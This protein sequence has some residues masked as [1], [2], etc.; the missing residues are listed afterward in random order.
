[1]KKRHCQIPCHGI[2]H[3]FLILFVLITFA[4]TEAQEVVGKAE[5]PGERD[6]LYKKGSEAYKEKDYLTA[7]KNL[8][9]FLV[10]NDEKLKTEYPD[11][12]KR[13]EKAIEVCEY[14]LRKSLL[15]ASYISG[16]GSTK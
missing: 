4:F 2:S 15:V 5:I 16:F 3:I 11:H 13:I 6:D 10:I 14:E 9:A 7:L 8:Y 12:R 1:M